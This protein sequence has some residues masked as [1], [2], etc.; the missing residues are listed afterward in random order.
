MKKQLNGD[1]WVATLIGI[2]NMKK[3]KNKTINSDAY[4][5]LQS[6]LSATT[7]IVDINVLGKW[8]TADLSSGTRFS[9]RNQKFD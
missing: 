3:E 5:Y 7:K 9:V 8:L 1:T 4:A 6:F 2:N